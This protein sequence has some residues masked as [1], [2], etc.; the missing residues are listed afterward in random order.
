MERVYVDTCVFMDAILD[1]D[2]RSSR[3]L[4]TPAKSL[5]SQSA[6]CQFRIIVSEWT[7]KEL[8]K[9][10]HEEEAK[11]LFSKISHK[12]DYCEFSEKDVEQAKEISDHWQDV[13]HGIIA[14][15]EDADS[16]VTR[17]LEDF[18]VLASVDAKLPSQI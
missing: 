18:R 13:L 4:G 7:L 11:E 16:I 15:R 1:R 9:N 5:F 14:E 3:D 8:Y 17:N 2:S 10:I 12:I 6:A